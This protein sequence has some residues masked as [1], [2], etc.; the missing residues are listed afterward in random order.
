MTKKYN[1]STFDSSRSNEHDETDGKTKAV[2]KNVIL[3]HS[4][5]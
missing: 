2:T 4:N 5:I 1:E 3:L